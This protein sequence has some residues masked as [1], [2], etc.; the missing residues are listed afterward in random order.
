MSLNWQL[1]ENFS[2]N[3]LGY[4]SRYKGK[5]QPE[6]QHPV[7][8]HLIFLTMTLGGDLTGNDKA[9]A[10]IKK[11]VAYIARVEPRLVTIQFGAEADKC[12]IW[13]GDKWVNFLT[14]FNP[15]PVIEQ[16]GK[17]SGWKFIIDD[18]W[19]DLYWGLSTNADRKP[20]RK[21]FNNFNK[22]TLEMLERGH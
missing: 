7:L 22:R 6:S 21:W 9:K 19:I 3:L 14:L 4:K 13:D 2:E 11:R 15:D 18:E 10:D 17:I 12:E 20:F 5:E 16:G 1:P 8:H